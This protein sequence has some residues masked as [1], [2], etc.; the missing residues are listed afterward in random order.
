[1]VPSGFRRCGYLCFINQFSK[2]WHRLASTASDRNSANISEK[3]DFWWSI[4]QKGTSIGH[5]GARND[6]TIRI[7]K[8]LMKWG[9]RGHWGHWGC[10]SN[11][12][13]RG[14]EAWKITTGDFRAIQVLDFSFILM[15]WKHIST[16]QS[17]LFRSVIYETPCTLNWKVGD[18]DLAHF[19]EDGPKLKL[20]SEITLGCTVGLHSF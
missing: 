2:K 4:P 12:G 18:S 7:S 15:F 16:P 3:L 6:P 11:W 1:M 17:C 9:H 10:W 5:F 19:F 14:S 8:F 13:C 20:P